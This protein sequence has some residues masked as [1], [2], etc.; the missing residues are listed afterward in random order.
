MMRDAFAG[1]SKTV[2][3]SYLYINRNVLVATYNC[4]NGIAKN[5]EIY[6]KY[7]AISPTLH[8]QLGTFIVKYNSQM[9]GWQVHNNYR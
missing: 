6:H 5:L 4:S 9:F 2:Q 8:M 1:L 3:Y 7:L